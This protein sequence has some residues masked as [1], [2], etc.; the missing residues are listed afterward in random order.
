VIALEMSGASEE[1]R[2]R[3]DKLDAALTKTTTKRADNKI[4]AAD[5]IKNFLL[6]NMD[7]VFNRQKNKIKKV[8][9]SVD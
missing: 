3:T 1:V 7:Q 8:F 6:K 9:H 2:K 5:N 4:S